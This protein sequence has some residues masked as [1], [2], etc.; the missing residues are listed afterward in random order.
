MSNHFALSVESPAEAPVVLSPVRAWTLLL[1]VFI[2]VHFAALFSPSLLDDADSTHA[3]AAQH[4]ALGGD[5]VTL[6]VDGVRYLEKTAAPLLADRGRLSHL[7]IQCLCYAPAAEL[8]R[9][10]PGGSYLGMGPAGLR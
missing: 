6:K 10:C 4:I 7:W 2:A 3:I 5:W 9:S 1:L 8:E